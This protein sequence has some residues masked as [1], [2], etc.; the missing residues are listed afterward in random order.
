MLP[1]L[2][3][4]AGA[5]LG[6]LALLPLPETAG[7]AVDAAKAA[8]AVA[9]AAPAA[10]DAEASA[11]G[12][13]A[14]SISAIS[15]PSATTSTTPAD[16]MAVAEEGRAGGRAGVEAAHLEAAGKGVEL[17][18]ATTGGASEADHVGLVARSGGA[19]G[20]VCGGVCCWGGGGRRGGRRSCRH[21]CRRWCALQAGALVS[22]RTVGVRVCVSSQVRR[23][24]LPKSV[25]LARVLYAR[26]LYAHHG[27]YDTKSAPWPRR[28]YTSSS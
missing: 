25:W 12:S 22:L 24:P 17:V 15:A 23:R 1:C 5:V 20:V 21:G 3:A 28:C 6:S 13:M 14:S 7:R 10:M 8:A 19:R 2:V 11:S 18:D 26:V 27:I 9:T 4:A 16:I